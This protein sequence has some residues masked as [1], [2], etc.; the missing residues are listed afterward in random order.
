MNTLIAVGT[1]AAFLYSRGRDGRARLLPEPRRRAGRLLRGGDHHHRAHPHRQRVRG[2]RE[3]ADDARAARAREPAADDG[4]RRARRRRR[5]TCPIERC[6]RGDDVVVRPGERLP[7]DGEVVVRRRAR[8]TSRCSP[9]SRCR[10]TK[11]PGDRVIGGTINRTG[12]FDYRATTLGADSVLAQIVKLMRDAQGSRAPIQRLA[13]RISAVFVPVGDRR[14]RSRRSSVWMSCPPAPA[15]GARALRGGGRGADHRLS[16]RDGARRADGG[17]GG[18]GRAPSRRA[19]QGRR[20]AAARGDVD[21][22]V[23]DKTGTVTEGTPQVVDFQLVE[24]D[25]EQ[26]LG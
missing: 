4:A 13:D 5:S 12:A 11:R 16:V 23:F 1:G 8:S 10:S 22:V 7:V 21:T 26:V 6:V 9:A 17:D 14:S 20:G 24:G 2:A 3:A 15:T 18:H 19:D 25:R